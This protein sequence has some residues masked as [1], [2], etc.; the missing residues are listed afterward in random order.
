MKPYEKITDQII[1]LLEQGVCPWKHYLNSPQAPQ[2]FTS[3]RE[4]NGFNHMWLSFFQSF[5]GYQSSEWLTFKQA[6]NLNGAIKKGSK[7][8]PVIYYDVMHLDANN[9]K[10]SE[11]LAVKK[12]PFLK[13]FTV[14]NMEQTE[15]IEWSPVE[16][17]AKEVNPIEAAEEIINHMPNAPKITY[18]GTGAYY[19]PSVDT[20]N[21]PKIADCTSEEEYYSTLFHELVHATG[22]ESR[23]N[24]KEITEKVNFG[25]QIYSK[26]ELTA[27]LGAAFLCSEA[28]ISEHVI[29]NQAAYLQ[30]WLKALK[31]DK[32]MIFEASAKAGQAAKY[33]IGG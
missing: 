18:G 1:G 29:E 14:F 20:V 28:G 3:K 2:N 16:S 19:R 10:V 25:S 27:E 21:V 22:H 4:Y 30:G 6:K 23:L 11:E 17:E 33:I 31:S 13:V 15:G 5:K 26:E 7:G 32:K 9:N 24:R 8:L 12:V